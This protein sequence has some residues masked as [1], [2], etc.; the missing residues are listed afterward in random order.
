MPLSE[1]EVV[2]VGIITRQVEVLTIRHEYE[3]QVMLYDEVEVEHEGYGICKA[4]TGSD[5]LHEGMVKTE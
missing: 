4:R 2:M 5:S 3:K 1:V